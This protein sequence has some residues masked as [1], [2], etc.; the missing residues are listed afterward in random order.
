MSHG[1]GDGEGGGEMLVYNVNAPVGFQRRSRLERGMRDWF[2]DG[3]PTTNKCVLCGPGGIG[4][5]T[6]V[7]TPFSPVASCTFCL[8][9]ATTDHSEHTNTL[10]ICPSEKCRQSITQKNQN[11]KDRQTNREIHR[12]K[13]TNT[14]K[15]TSTLSHTNTHSGSERARERETERQSKR[16]SEE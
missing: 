6:L 7:S 2:E 14:H 15:H 8:V 16:A 13:H 12:H 10:T 1:N 9:N 4:K 3:G 11:K 5:S